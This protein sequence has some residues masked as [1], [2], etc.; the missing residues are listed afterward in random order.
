[1]VVKGLDL[2][3]T[4]T[5]DGLRR[6]S[7]EL[8]VWSSS[9]SAA[10]PIGC[11]PSTSQP[12]VRKEPVAM[13]DVIVVGG[14]YAGLAAAMQLGR[15]RRT[16]LVVDAGQRRNRV[17][18]RAHGVLGFDGESPAV[19]AAKGK[20][21]VLEYPS[22]H[23]LDGAATAARSVA[24]GFA[25]SVGGQEHFA[26]RLILATGVVDEIPSIPG[27]PERWGKTIFH[28]PY[29]DGYE[30]ERGRLGVLG[31][32]PVAQHYAAIVAEWSS[33]EGTTL[34]LNDGVAPSTG[35]LAELTSR[36]I[37]VESASVL[38]AK[39]GASGMELVVRGGRQ[40]GL[41]AVFVLPQTR[42]PGAFAQQLGCEIESGATGSVYKTD[43]RTKETTVKGVYA[44]GDAGLALHSVTFAMADGARAGTSAHQSLVFGEEP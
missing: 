26:K 36:G 5:V 1:M 3:R 23:W 42:L 28:C 7:R 11:T 20:H 16:V 22:V 43:P 19:I 38:E 40:Y 33:R 6:R 17:V 8:R 10:P 21:Q 31:A 18:S 14:S 27:F 35:E 24:G 30:L 34:F 12:I 41:A 13:T 39:D 29:C 9:H 25:V 44:A 2:R 37:H 4:A 32:G 15:A